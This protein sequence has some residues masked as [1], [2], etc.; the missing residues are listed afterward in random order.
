VSSPVEDGVEPGDPGDADQPAGREPG[1]D[2]HEQRV[3]RRMPLEVRKR[4]EEALQAHSATDLVEGQGLGRQARDEMGVEPGVGGEQLPGEG[5][6]LERA[7]EH[8][9]LELGESLHHVDRR[10]SVHTQRIGAPGSAL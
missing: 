6:V 7:S 2:R 3:L 9:Q 5:L 8:E 4:T 1:A 10:L